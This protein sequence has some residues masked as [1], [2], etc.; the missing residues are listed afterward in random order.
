M[1]FLLFNQIQNHIYQL[2][3]IR[4]AYYRKFVEVARGD[5]NYYLSI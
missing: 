3:D 2:P 4:T 1:K 5:E